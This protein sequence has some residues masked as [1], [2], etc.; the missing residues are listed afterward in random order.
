MEEHFVSGAPSPLVNEKI[1][2][3][4]NQASSM[5]LHKPEEDV[6]QSLE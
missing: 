5:T 2:Q 1:N 6:I 4:L 3:E